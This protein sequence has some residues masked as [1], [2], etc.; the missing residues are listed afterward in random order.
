MTASLPTPLHQE[1]LQE[2]VLGK[3][4]VDY[5]VPAVSDSIPVWKMVSTQH[6]PIKELKEGLDAVRVCVHARALFCF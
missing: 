2:G 6:H 5:Q 3:R 1:M 4:R